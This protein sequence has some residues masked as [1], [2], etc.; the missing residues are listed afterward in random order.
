M[1]DQRWRLLLGA[2]ALVTVLTGCTVVSGGT[3]PTINTGI[4]P[5]GGVGP[6]GG[7]GPTAPASVG[8][9]LTVTGVEGGSAQVTVL[10]VGPAAAGPGAAVP[11][12]SRLLVVKLSYQA[13]TTFA[14]DADLSLVVIGSDGQTYRTSF[15]PVLGCTNFNAGS[16]SL[17]PGA[18]SVG[19]VPF[20]L[21]ATVTVATVQFGW[22]TA[23]PQWTV[24]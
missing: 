13:A 19:C 11:A 16:V 21:P 8:S 5:T 9:A 7:T 23:Q 1:R 17:T 12:G 10:G 14:D 24:S 18:V 20:V 6:T 15:S 2:G 4:G 3:A 22:P